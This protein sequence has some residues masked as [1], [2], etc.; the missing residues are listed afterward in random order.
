MLARIEKENNIYTVTFERTIKHSVEEVWAMLTENE[1]LNLWFDELKVEDLREGGRILFDMQDG[2]YEEMRITELKVPE[3]LE[4]TWGEDIVRFELSKNH[5]GC[6]LRL[7][8]MLQVLTAHTPR[9]IAGWHVCLNVIESLL[10]GTEIPS[11]KE[12]W[13]RLYEQYIDALKSFR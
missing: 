3:V 6:T 5:N 10:D 2:T 11:R 8:E 1:K 12:S 13:E 4:F 7:I 9:D